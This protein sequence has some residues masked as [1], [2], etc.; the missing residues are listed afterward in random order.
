MRHVFFV[1]LCIIV[2]KKKGRDIV[3]EQNALSKVKRGRSAASA[4]GYIK[5]YI[6][7]ALFGFIM[8]QARLPGGT[9]PFCISAVCA[10]SE[11]PPVVL[12]GV[13]MGNLFGDE[14][15]YTLAC[16]LAL[17]SRIVIWMLS[18]RGK[19]SV[20]NMNDGATCRAASALIGAICAAVMMYSGGGIYEMTSLMI[21]CCAAVFGNITF[22]FFFDG[23]Y[24]YDEL[25]DIGMI[26]V[27]IA[28]SLA[29]SDIDIDGTPL[30]LMFAIFATLYISL[31]L[32]GAFGC[33]GG[34]ILG[35]ICGEGYMV[36]LPVM[37]IA[38][39]AFGSFGG[40]AALF[41]SAAVFVSGC[42]CF[43]GAESTA[44]LILPLTVGEAL[45]IIPYSMGYIR[46]KKR[47]DGGA[48]IERM[49]MAIRE[50]EKRGR[51]DMLSEAMMSLS[52]GF[53]EMLGGFKSKN[54]TSL[55]A[56]CR[57]VWRYHCE[58]CPIECQCHDMDNIEDDAVDNAMSR[59]M[60]A[61]RE[62]RDKIGMLLGSKCPK[63]D[64]IIRDINDG[65]AEIIDRAMDERADI[66]A[67]D[68]EAAAGMISDGIAN[69]VGRYEQDKLLSERMRR[70]MLSLG[71]AT[72][73]VV[74]F[75]ER[76]KYIIATGE[77]L[78]R[79]G[80][81]VDDIRSVCENVCKKRFC[82]P[83]FS[84]DNG[85][86][87]MTLEADTSFYVEHAGRQCQK[88]GEEYMGDS[89][90]HVENRDGYVYF[91]ICDGMGSGEIA[92]KTADICRVF[93]EK[94][95]KAGNSRVLTLDMLNT[96]I[97]NK[98]V[99]CYATVDL[100]EIDLV[101]GTASFVKSGA[102]PSYVK[103]G[104]NIFKI[105]SGTFPI[106]I[107]DTPS[108]EMTEFELRDGDVMMLCSDGVA[109]DFDVSRSLDP[110]WFLS[111]IEREW[112]DDLEM[113]SEKIIS[114]AAEQN[115]RS[116]DMTVELIRINKKK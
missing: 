2:S 38:A 49:I 8:S 56:M 48:H 65:A 11:M 78:M 50:N 92:S 43:F 5:K 51:I 22:S 68:Y 34:L 77:G 103:R 26:S 13:M 20:T 62:E 47:R 80:V 71:I 6:L 70:A 116:D 66:F 108:A 39:G 27:I 52:R 10:V 17:A 19:G 99:E 91:F 76:K 110:S 93:L 102:T 54:R 23:R 75:G 73:N 113:M 96:F 58:D 16:A 32:G 104:A 41:T 107:M 57:A 3:T 18:R 67:L 109:Q 60:A 45:A 63:T 42:V 95:L 33:V 94:M 101:L 82:P 87:A 12:L 81:G 61:G 111:F 84:I 15:V 9:A 90:S 88:R 24:M 14:R 85:L 35:V 64:A 79:S 100:L 106:G 55:D 74:V 112:T 21:M 25:S 98:G 31:R 30:S 28:I 36:I 97:K 40:A 59:L 37:G 115:H 69:S 105:E 1:L 4:F 46:R 114:A 83:T 7:L 53:N 89:V 44:E 72:E 29:L 86:Y